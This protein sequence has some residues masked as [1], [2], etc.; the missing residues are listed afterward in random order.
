MSDQQFQTADAV[1]QADASALAGKRA[2]HEQ[3]T[4][5]S[6]P[7]LRESSGEAPIRVPAD[8]TDAPFGISPIESVSE[9]APASMPSAEW[10]L[11]G[12]QWRGQPS[13]LDSN[14]EPEQEVDGIKRIGLA[15]SGGGIRSA[16]FSLGVLQRMAMRD[17]LKEI[18][19]LSTVSG[20]GYMG[21]FLSAWIHRSS[22][23]DVWSAL[24][25]C[26]ENNE[27]EPPQVQWLR[28]YSNYLT[29]RVGALSL[30][31]LTVAAT[32][33]RNV[34]LNMCVLVAFVAAIVVVP[35]FFVAPVQALLN[36]ASVARAGTAIFGLI[37]LVACFIQLSPRSRQRWPRV[38]RP[39]LVYATV[40]APGFLTALFGAAF[41]V[42]VDDSAPWVHACLFTMLGIV[43]IMAVTQ[44]ALSR[45]G[46]VSSSPSVSAFR[47]AVY[48]PAT[49]VVVAVG[50]L[51]LAGLNHG[52]HSRGA[53]AEN[54]AL[55]LV[56]GAPLLVGVVA[57][58]VT[59]WIGLLGR[60]Y[61]EM[62]REWW[63][64][65]GGAAISVGAVWIAWCAL[66]TYVPMYL[67]AWLAGIGPWTNH[68]I[69]AG[70]IG[71][72]ATAIGL[73]RSLSGNATSGKTLPMRASIAAILATV[74]L[75]M[76]VIAIACGVFALM[77]WNTPILPQGNGFV[78]V[79]YW[80]CCTTQV[81][82]PTAAFAAL[83]YLPAA[84]MVLLASAI[85][86]V[87]FG[88]R[89]DINRF[90]LHDMYKNR[91]IRCY[92]GASNQMRKPNLFTGFDPNDDI[93]LADLAPLQSVEPAPVRGSS[94]KRAPENDIPLNA[95][96]QRPFPIFNT[97]L[98]LVH[99]SELAWQERKS[100]LFVLTPT[101]CG[102][103][104]APAT[105][106]KPLFA[107]PCTQTAGAAPEQAFRPTALY[108]DNASRDEM[109]AYRTAGPH[110]LPANIDN[111]ERTGFTIGMAMAT[112]GA[113]VSP[114]MGAN[115]QPALAMLMTFFNIRLGRWCPNPGKQDWRRSGPRSN[116]AWLIAE[117]SGNTNER[118]SFVYLSDGGHF[119]NT[120]VYELVRRRC[121]H[122]VMVDAGADPAR[123]FED[124]GNLIRKVRVDLGAEIELKLSDL[125]AL[126]TGRSMAGFVRGQVTYAT[127]N[128]RATGKILLIKPTLGKDKLE[129]ADV[130]NYARGDETF[131]QQ[132]TLDQWFDESQFEAYRCLG[133]FL[134]KAAFDANPGF[135]T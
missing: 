64:R 129:P 68:V 66:A 93:A 130:Y 86:A 39:L 35:L 114:N 5:A 101:F 104:L 63:S 4:A 117:A 84:W 42:S 36:H 43:A 61:P 48:A 57:V 12:D 37:A 79:T 110:N 46:P 128:E 96:P 49:A 106:D 44:A 52:W 13:V 132:T 22:P 88:W 40:I 54:A 21:A 103:N 105:G 17:T 34:A 109:S 9:D 74:V 53:T 126:K 90:S 10:S 123:A 59:L 67:P 58:S 25:R 8:A 122:I 72:L 31:A 28:R 83:H 99:G 38:T 19:M 50:F 16:T 56:F 60:D 133:S 121:S 92:L 51:M 135:F 89:V 94:A 71:S 85:T 81:P 7:P 65:V 45:L 32:Y 91:L 62:Y 131:P 6:P 87:V 98:N 134:T 30:D 11:T 69:A 125:Y 120:A 118:R 15:L 3:S 77:Q 73:V 102:Y 113:A 80:V 116:L 26:P 127:N 33:L 1:Y 119:E 107:G 75:V 95:E 14:S 55:M 76:L 23:A 111:G 20:G 115:T 70:W 97:A 100:A 112:S 108:A 41:L 2:L 82:A 124:L 47:F 78:D 18:D 29:P 24:K 27:T